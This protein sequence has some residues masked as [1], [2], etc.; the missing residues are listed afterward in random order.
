MDRRRFL[1]V[2][3]AAAANGPVRAVAAAG[4]Y[5]TGL[6]WRIDKPGLR[7][8]YVFGTLHLPDARLLPLPEPV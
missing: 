3:A 6:L 1:A 7:P 5:E 2:M 8:S 4:A